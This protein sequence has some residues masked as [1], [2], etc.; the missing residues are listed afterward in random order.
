MT[1]VLGCDSI[2]VVT[3]DL[4]EMDTVNTVMF[5]CAIIAPDTIRIDDAECPTVEIISYEG[6]DSDTTFLSVENCTGPFGEL[7][8]NLVNAAGCDSVV[9]QLTSEA[10]QS[11]TQ[12][13]ESTC[14][15]N[16]PNDTL[17][18]DGRFCDSLIITTF[19]HEPLLSTLVEVPVCDPEELFVDSL[20]FVNN[21]GCDSLVVLRA[22]LVDIDTMRLFDETCDPNLVGLDTTMVNTQDC[23]SLIIIE[24]MLQG[25]PD[26]TRLIRTTCEDSLIGSVDVEDLININGCDSTVVISF[27]GENFDP[28]FNLFVEAP[29]CEGETNGIVNLEVQTGVQVLWLFD[30][31]VTNTRGDLA[32]GEY[33]IAL[34][35]NGCDTIINVVVPTASSIV[36]NFEVD[37]LL[38]SDF[39]GVIFPQIFGGQLPYTFNWQ[40]GSMD[41]IRQNLV[42]GT[43]SVTVTDALGCAVVDSVD[44]VNVAGVTFSVSKDN[45]RCYEEN[46]GRIEVE[47]L[48]GT[49]PL[50][51]QWQDGNED[52]I[53]EDLEAGEYSCTISDANNCRVVINRIIFQP[54][55]LL[56]DLK[57][58]ASD[59]LEA[60]VTGG[61]PPFQY[62]WNDGT[63][64]R[65]IEE[66]ILGFGYEVTVTDAN[67]CTAVRDEV[68]AQVSTSFIDFSKV[69][70]FPNPNNGDF[71][72]SFDPN[73]ELENVIIYNI[74]GQEVEHRKYMIG[75]NV[76]VSIPNNTKGTFFINASFKQ[77]RYIQKMLIF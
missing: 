13:E 21:L 7:F 75:N 54:D 67:N 68:F 69:S 51:V 4:V 50:E 72:F 12:L 20:F 66:P 36:L 47:V 30:E 27:V 18:L 63:T 10:E 55:D 46:N 3:Y 52:L 42:D 25:E 16:M 23:P 22:F 49:A 76:M 15:E 37:Y 14:I 65:T 38:C 45:V 2:V 41:S 64:S 9:V 24:T 59:E 62:L 58:N 73:L 48:S 17:V 35:Q 70:L 56:I 26:T 61:I 1:S 31:Q 43:Y 5:A 19:I 39:G 28:S 60:V 32:S 77:G 71:Q 6:L 57:F 11:I 29:N 33:Q 8:F 34:S 53:R 74:Y 40:D 44:I